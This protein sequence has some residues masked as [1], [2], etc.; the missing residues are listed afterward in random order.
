M[1]MLVQGHSLLKY[2][3][4]CACRPSDLGGVYLTRVQTF[5]HVSNTQMTS[6]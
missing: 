4:N 2:F 3:V 1:L 6:M 5:S